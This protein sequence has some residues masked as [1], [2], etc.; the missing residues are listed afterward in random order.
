MPAVSKAQQKAMAVALHS[1][2]QLSKKNSGL[3]DMSKRQ[4]SEF[5]S[6]KTSGLPKRA[7]R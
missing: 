4:L 7:K 1:P 6:T 2:G 3:L 5:A